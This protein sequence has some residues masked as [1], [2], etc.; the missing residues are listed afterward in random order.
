MRGHALHNAQPLFGAARGSAPLD[1]ALGLGST[2][3]VPDHA[4]VVALLE[5][6]EGLEQEENQLLQSAHAP[7]QAVEG[8][9]GA[10]NVEHEEHSLGQLLFALEGAGVGSAPAH[11]DVAAAHNAIH[12]PRVVQL[13]VRLLPK[14][15][16]L[17]L[18][19]LV[20][21]QHRT[22]LDG[23]GQHR[24][25]QALVLLQVGT[26]KFELLH[27]SGMGFLGHLQGLS[28]HLL[29]DALLQM[30]GHH[31]QLLAHVQTIR[32]PTSTQAC[33]ARP[34]ASARELVATNV[35]L[36]VPIPVSRPSLAHVRWALAIR[37]AGRDSLC[38]VDVV[39]QVQG[40]VAR[41]SAEQKRATPDI[42]GEAVLGERL[43]EH[44]PLRAIPEI[45]GEDIP[46]HALGLVSVALKMTSDLDQLARAVRVRDLPR[47]GQA[48]ELP[49]EQGQ[50]GEVLGRHVRRHRAQQ[51]HLALE[52]G[53]AHHVAG[54]DVPAGPVEVVPVERIAGSIRQDDHPEALRNLDVALLRGLQ[55]LVADPSPLLCAPPRNEPATVSESQLAV[56][57]QRL[58][59]ADHLRRS[60]VG[61]IHD[62]AAA[63]PRGAHQGAVLAHDGPALEGLRESE[64]LHRGV[65]VQLNVFALAL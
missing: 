50:L 22:H 49:E 58:E 6:V 44:L 23:L 59:H 8:V 48:P 5:T 56:V 40:H 2:P 54:E 57:R 27:V 21:L 64:R 32:P 55:C 28:L 24:L 34:A 1:Q 43:E 60:F 63:V 11:V 12:Q 3:A 38:P 39:V 19:R 41:R 20:R 45:E 29:V 25:P 36:A 18:S 61:L 16:A 14:P 7:V 42:S 13:P 31:D 35:L 47:V 46:E 9:H 17:P 52:I 26:C 4:K 51:L 62:Q 65:A 33:S 30:F 15:D 37:V 10:R 53:V